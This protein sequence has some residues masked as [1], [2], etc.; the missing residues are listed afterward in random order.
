MKINCELNTSRRDFVRALAVGGAVVAGV[1]LAGC[2]KP[3]EAS[4]AQGAVTG[5]VPETWDLESELVIVGGGGSGFMAAMA[6]AEKGVTSLI[7]EKSEKFGGDSALCAGIFIG[8]NPEATKEASGEADTYDKWYADQ[9]NGAQYSQKGLAGGTVGDTSLVELQAQ[10]TEETFQW[11]RDECGVDWQP[12]DYCHNCWTPQP[13]WDTVYPRDWNVTENFFSKLQAHADAMDQ[14]ESMTGCE[15][16]EIIMNPEGRAVGVRARKED[17]TLVTAKARRAV[18]I[19]SGSFSANQGL[20]SEYLGMEIGRMVNPGNPASTGDGQRMVQQV[21]GQLRDMDLGSAWFTATRGSNSLLLVYNMTMYGDRAGKYM[22]GILVN[23]EGVRYASENLGYNLG[24]VEIAKQKYNEAFYVADAKG[25]AVGDDGSLFRA[26][27]KLE[28]DEIFKADTLEELAVRMNVPEDAFLA[29]VERWNSY[30]DAG[31]DDEF[32][33][34]LAGDERIETAPFY[35]IPLHGTPYTTYGGIAVDDQTRVLDQS[36]NPIQGLYAAGI[37]TGSF[38]EQAGM[39]YL[40]GVSQTLIFGRRAG[41]IAADMD[42][43]A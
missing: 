37:C 36:D 39:F 10:L 38:A 13:S 30:I 2:G 12:F 14:I 34:A 7:L 3:K 24:G 1:G 29:Q 11:T 26:R 27:C 19:T 16:Y 32:G 35:A 23:R 20:I 9:L 8:Y 28:D 4:T 31:K 15:V 40:G 41:Q 22:P 21:G 17:G 43:W 5:S 6:A 18:V 33:R 42:A 25:A